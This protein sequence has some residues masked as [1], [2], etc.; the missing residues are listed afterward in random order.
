M[1]SD[2]PERLVARL[3]D[4]VER[5]IAPLTQAGVRR[6]DKV[7]GAAILRKA[8]GSLV[9]AGTNEETECPLWHGEVVAIRG[10]HELASTERPSPKDCLFLSTH[11]PCSLCLS[12]ITWAG[13][14]NFYYLFSYEDSRDD[15][16]IPH[17]LRILEEV[18]DCPDGNYRPTNKYWKSH[19]MVRL[20]ASWGNSE[21]DGLRERVAR[22]RKLYAAMSKTYQRSKA[23][24]GIPL[25]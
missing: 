13:F 12:A 19:D 8:D 22:L 14:D 3:L 9:F 11:E 25:A 21:Q 7:F 18:F 16:S 15:F 24:G 20:I 1:L 17:D 5:H 6:G 2:R 10:F 23:A 4:V